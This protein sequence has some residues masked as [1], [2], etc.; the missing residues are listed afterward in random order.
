VSEL[1][2]NSPEPDRDTGTARVPAV[3]SGWSTVLR[4]GIRA[5]LVAV[6]VAVAVVS[7]V[8]VF[9]VVRG[10]PRFGD[11]AVKNSSEYAILVE[12][13]APDD[14][15]WISVGSLEPY[16]SGTFHDIID[17]GPVWVVRFGA[18]GYHDVVTMPRPDRGSG[19]EEIDV[20]AGTIDRLRGAGAPP[21]PCFRSDCP[22]VG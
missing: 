1:P 11:L 9:L 13:S 8:A 21:S 16:S 2:V 5:S 12:L 6:G 22:P 10:P 19:Q 14:E 20:P 4:A 7:V 15:G 17:P 3:T 18:Q